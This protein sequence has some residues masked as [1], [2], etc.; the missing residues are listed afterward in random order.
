MLHIFSNTS[1]LHS[2]PFELVPITAR[3]GELNFVFDKSAYFINLVFFHKM[4]IV[5]LFR[6]PKDGKDTGGV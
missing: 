4:L 2:K 3:S 5:Y 6:F 1:E